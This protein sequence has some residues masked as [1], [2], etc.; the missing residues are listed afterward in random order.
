MHRG[1]N[2][3]GPVADHREVHA[4]RDRALQLWNFG[5]DLADDFDDVGAGLPLD[6]DDDRRRALV[7]AAG[8]IVLQAVDDDRDVA[9]RDRRAIAVGDDDRLVGLC[10]G[11]LVV[12]SD[13]IGLL[14]AVERTLRSG[15]IRTRDRVAQILHRRFHRRPAAPD[16]PAPAPPA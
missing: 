12:G 4:G 8:A 11:D 1:A 6:I 10:R 9:D 13:G 15:D 2:G 16:R 5:A 7:P 14:G 3:Y